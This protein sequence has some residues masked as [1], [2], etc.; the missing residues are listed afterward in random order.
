MRVNLNKKD[1]K[2]DLLN[3]NILYENKK[4]VDEANQKLKEF[5][6]R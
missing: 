2:R 5:E 1:N 4:K 3:E 6:I